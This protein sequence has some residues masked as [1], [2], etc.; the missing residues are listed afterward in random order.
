M[1]L[2]RLVRLCC[3]ASALMLSACGTVDKPPTA[4]PSADASAR[5]KNPARAF[6]SSARPAPGTPFAD[7]EAKR[8][9]YFGFGEATISSEA[10]EILRQNAQKLK[11]EPHLLVTLVGHTDN[12][13]SAAYNLAVADRRTEA[14]HEKLRSFGVP[15]NQIRRLA[16]GS[17]HSSKETCDSETCRQSMRKVEL[18]YER[19]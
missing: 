6:A 16:V 4:D 5:Q 14:V 7:Q 8:T 3:L 9:V 12:L 1:P 2:S 18:I 13:G 17:E 11:D 15:R 19:R 10:A